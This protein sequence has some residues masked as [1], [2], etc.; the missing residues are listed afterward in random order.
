MV[1]QA[2]LILLDAHDAQ[3]RRRNFVRCV[4]KQKNPKNR[5]Y[6]TEKGTRT[7]TLVKEADFESAGLPIPPLHR[8]AHPS[9]LPLLRKQVCFGKSF[10]LRVP[11]LVPHNDPSTDAH[12]SIRSHP[13]L[14]QQEAVSAL[15]AG[16]DVVVHAPTGAGKTLIFELWANMGKPKGKA[17]TLC[18]PRRWLMTSWLNGARE[19]P[20]IATGDL[21]EKCPIL[22]ATLETQKSR[23]VRAGRTCWLSMNTK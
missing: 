13:D 12:S 1:H 2:A 18:P 9:R 3:Q 5:G 8:S 10:L 14:W 4:R 15:R 21:A 19:W 20:V 7:P 23:L 6:G 17:V 22:A 11:S 16:Q